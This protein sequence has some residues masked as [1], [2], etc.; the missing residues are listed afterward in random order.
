MCIDISILVCRLYLRSD[1]SFPITERSDN[2][3]KT[4]Q[5]LAQDTSSTQQDTQQGLIKPIISFL[6]SLTVFQNHR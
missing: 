5:G 2:L 6:I 3:P 1:I 4:N